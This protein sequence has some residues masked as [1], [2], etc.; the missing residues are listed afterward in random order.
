MLPLLVSELLLHNPNIITSLYT[1]Q[2]N[3]EW[4]NGMLNK[5]SWKETILLGSSLV[6]E[7][8]NPEVLQEGF[9]ENGIKTTVGSIAVPS[10]RL[11]NDYF[12]L[13]RIMATCTNCPKNIVI[14]VQDLGLKQVDLATVDKATYD[15]VYAR[16]K[17]NYLFDSNG[18]HAL[19]KV[20][21]QDAVFNSYE[22][23]L[24]N[25]SV[26]RTYYFR[27]LIMNYLRQ[28]VDTFTGNEEVNQ[29]ALIKTQVLAD[30]GYGFWPYTQ[31]LSDTS[32]ANSINNYKIYLGKY[33]IGTGE[34]VFLTQILTLAKQKHLHIYIVLT[35]ESNYYTTVFSKETEMFRSYIKG[36]GQK[37]NIPVIDAIDIMPNAYD[38][39]ADINH[40]NKNGANLFSKYLAGA[41]S[42][43]MTVSTH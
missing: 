8:V 1:Q 34:T 14:G 30:P 39:Y 29:Q 37:Y 7:G 19:A 33:K 16:I 20:A 24:Y 11:S 17:Q 25:E 27:K 31:R 15:E 10:D 41:L 3:A 22:K 43:L 32:P 5:N 36:V 12:T 38:D 9:R 18:E 21:K 35:P 13:N 23:Q 4:V 2:P 6:R 26:I 40:L 42:K 28:R